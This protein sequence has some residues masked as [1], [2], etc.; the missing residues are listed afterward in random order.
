MISR[1]E[2]LA[3]ARQHVPPVAEICRDLSRRRFIVVGP[4][5]TWVFS[6]TWE[7]ESALVKIHT[8]G[9]TVRVTIWPTFHRSLA[10]THSE[11]LSQPI[12]FD[13]DRM[14]WTETHP[15]LHTTKY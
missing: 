8:N 6:Y 1:L 7:G 11:P 10:R 4:I 2:A 12:N 14:F 3:H 13:A 5:V 15:R 9:T